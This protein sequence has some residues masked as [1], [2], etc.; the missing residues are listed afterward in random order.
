M[1]DEYNIYEQ[2]KESLTELDEIELEKWLFDLEW[3]AAH[4]NI[5]ADFQTRSHPSTAKFLYQKI[6]NNTIPEFDYKPVSR[7]CVWALADIGTVE[8]KNYI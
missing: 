2:D 3:H 4:D 8:A 5:A 6:T 7:K 1:L